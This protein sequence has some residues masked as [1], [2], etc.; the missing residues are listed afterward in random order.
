MGAVTVTPQRSSVVD[1][2]RGAAVAVLAVAQIAVAALGGSQQGVVANEYRTPLL[3]AG[4]AFGIWSLIYVGFLAYAVYQLLPSQRGRAVHRATGWWL[5]A[6]AVFNAAFILAFGARWVL[7]AEL[8]IVALT[9]VLAVAFGRLSRVRATDTA[10]RVL[11]RAPVAVYTGWVSLAVVLGTAATGVWAGLPGDGT[12]ATVLA[13]VVLAVAAVIVMLV[14]T[15][16]TA[17][18]GYAAAAAWALAGIALNDPPTAVGV[19]AAL[20]VVVVLF[21]AVRRVNASGDPLRAAWG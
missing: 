9:V 7:L 2:V 12:L 10:E 19:A 11:L 4:W 1:L 8:A 21:T 13:V 5:A 15:N 16:G 3:A 6:S 14:I 20:A 18:V 17:V